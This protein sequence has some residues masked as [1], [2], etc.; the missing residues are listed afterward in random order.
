MEAAGQAQSPADGRALEAL[1]DVASGVRDL[2]QQ[3]GDLQ[4]KAAGLEARLEQAMVVI[5]RSSDPAWLE[6]YR[7]HRAAVA[8]G[9]P[10][11]EL[12]DADQFVQS[13][14]SAINK[15]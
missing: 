15:H 1:A 9:E 4:R 5:R 13:V 10:P 11:D 14:Q 2:E 12:V 6:R 7:A 8:E 3:A